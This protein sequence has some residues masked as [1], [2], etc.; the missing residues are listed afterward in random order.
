[1]LLKRI[2]R[3]SLY[4]PAR[5]LDAIATLAF[6]LYLPYFY[7]KVRKELPGAEKII[8]RPKYKP[9]D[10]IA[11]GPKDDIRDEIYSNSTDSHNLLVHAGQAFFHPE[12]A[13]RMLEEG[14]TPTGSLYRYVPGGYK[15][16]PSGDM[17][18][19]WLYVYALT[20]IKRPDLLK[21]LVYHYIG[22]CMVL[23]DK[24]NKFT[25]RSSNSGVN[26]LD[27]DGWPLGK[28][29]GFT[30]PF[31]EK[32]VKLFTIP[33]GISQPT[34]PGAYLNTASILALAARDIGWHWNLAYWF[35]YWT[36]NGW[37]HE[38]FPYFFTKTETW[39][40]TAHIASLSLYVLNKCKSGKKFGLRWIAEICAPEG[41]MQPFIAGMAN[42]CGAL[43][44]ENRKLALDTLMSQRPIWP[45]HMPVNNS[46]LKIDHIGNDMR[47]SMMALAAH[48]LM[49][50]K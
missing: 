29:V 12:N 28:E 10:I 34:T 22:N 11:L 31:I 16:A 26:F 23:A 40:Y 41:N 35:H 18:A 2:L 50:K 36:N 33:F 49:K 42:E 30:V 6:M 14:L 24:N 7:F 3:W 38:R 47:Y 4:F 46:Y 25:A 21:K 48:Q 32:Y 9:E 1:M 19:A 44:E 17:L 37:F 43:S 15:E 5:I 8:P 45:Q 13:E 27:A 20:G 39:Y